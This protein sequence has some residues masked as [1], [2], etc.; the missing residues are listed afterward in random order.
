MRLGECNLPL[1]KALRRHGG[2]DEAAVGKERG[3][4]R[5]RPIHILVIHKGAQGQRRAGLQR[6]CQGAGAVALQPVCQVSGLRHKLRP[7]LGRDRRTG[8]HPLGR[9]KDHQ[10]GR[11][12][13][14]VD[15]SKYIIRLITNQ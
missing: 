8:V 13:V 9:G 12:L 15:G 1:G 3:G 5:R 10:H 6:G 11:L 4:A 7:A 2:K 14:Y